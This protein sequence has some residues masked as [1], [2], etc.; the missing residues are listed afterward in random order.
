MI[1]EFVNLYQ[2]R[3][4]GFEVLNRELGPVATIRF[5]QQYEV[6]VG[7]YSVERHQWLDKMDIDDIAEAAHKRRKSKKKRQ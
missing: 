7:D 4:R 2:I 1:S 6:G 5:L 3:Q